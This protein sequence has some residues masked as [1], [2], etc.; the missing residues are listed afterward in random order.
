LLPVDGTVTWLA[1]HTID[2]VVEL[3][4]PVTIV[5]P[6]GSN[7]LVDAKLLNRAVGIVPTGQSVVVELEAFPFTR[8]G[9]IEGRIES[10]G[11][12]AVSDETL[13]PVFPVRVRLECGAADKALCRQITPGMV[14]T[15]GVRTG[16]RNILSFLMSPIDEAQIDA[17]RER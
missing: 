15:A 7:L 14:A 4:K 16:R 6:Q 17:G 9:T 12:D 2:G 3:A 11:S 13:G 1:V 10:I 5:V 8:H